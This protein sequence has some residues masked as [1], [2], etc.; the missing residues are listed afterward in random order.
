MTRLTY[1]DPTP[2]QMCSLPAISTGRDVMACA[3]TGSGKTV[4]PSP[5]FYHPLS[6]SLSLSLSLPR[7]LSLSLSPSPSLSFSLSLSLSL[8]LFLLQPHIYT[9]THI[10]TSTHTYTHTHIHTHT[11]TYTHITSITQPIQA[12]FL[13]PVMTAMLEQGLH[14]QP[15]EPITLIISPTKE[16]ARQVGKLF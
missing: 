4:S 7:P 15:G 3:T 13:I 14:S 11:N 2:I 12:A 10:R 6:L 9:H 16:L 1:Q 5:H 8:S